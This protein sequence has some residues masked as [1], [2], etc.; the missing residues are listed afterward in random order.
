[1]DITFRPASDDPALIAATA[2]YE[3]LWRSDGERIVEAL[4][5][6]TGLRFAEQRLEGIVHEGISRSH[7][8][9]L[10]ASYDGETKRG[11]LIH[12]LARRLVDQGES[13]SDPSSADEHEIIDLFLFDAWSD[14]YGDAFARRQVEVE[15][16]RRPMY[17]EAW[18]ATL[19]LD[20]K[21]R[22]AKLRSLLRRRTELP[23]RSGRLP[24]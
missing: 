19:V 13:P 9:R 20:R 4:C 12:E 15:S 14:L 24:E 3:R 21:A 10:R 22:A 6:L 11:T 7:P 17:Q 5:G 16:Q 2:E 1:M 23:D 18:K 8:L